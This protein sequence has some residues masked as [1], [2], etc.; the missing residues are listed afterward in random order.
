M[1]T[2][3]TINEFTTA[4]ASQE[5]APGGGSAA[6]LAGLLGA[7]LLEMAIN[8]TRDRQEYAADD[9]LLADKQNEAVKLRTKL[10][11]L[12]DRD[13]AAFKAVVA[14]QVLPQDNATDCRK[15]T[16]AVA[17][18]IK[19]AAEVPLVT[20]RACLAL[21]EIMTAILDKV[22]P[23]AV[24]DLGVGALASHTGLVGALFSTAINLPMLKDENLAKSLGAE[25]ARLRLAGDEHLAAIRERIFG[26][27]TF[28]VLKA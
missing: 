21:M 28:A 8:L 13:A 17:A 10:K 1:L 22:N 15:R 7:S 5:P 19:E 9:S 4:L 14:A 3:L 23:H 11:T 27:P 6:A 24:S 20:A 12:I 25:A 16:A 26:T 18:A 2:N